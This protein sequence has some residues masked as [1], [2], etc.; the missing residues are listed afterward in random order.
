M[1]YLRTPEALDYLELE[2]Q[3]LVNPSVS[4]GN[5]TWVLRKSSACSYVLSCLSHPSPFTLDP[6]QI[7][8]NQNLFNA[9]EA[10]A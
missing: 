6:G 7:T 10:E 4:V 2:L 9:M 8:E 3:A 1:Q 5:Q